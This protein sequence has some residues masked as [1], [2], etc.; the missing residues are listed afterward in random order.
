VASIA[1]RSCSR[2]SPFLAVSCC[3][4]FLPERASDDGVD[5]IEERLA[6]CAANQ[7]SPYAMAS[8]AFAHA[9]AGHGDLPARAPTGT[10]AT[11]GFNPAGDKLLRRRRAA[12]I[13]GGL[14]YAS[15]G[16]DVRSVSYPLAFSRGQRRDPWKLGLLDSWCGR[17]FE[18]PR[19]CGRQ[20]FK[21]VRL[22]VP[23]KPRIE[24]GAARL[25]I[26]EGDPC[27]APSVAGT[28]RYLWRTESAKS[29]SVVSELCHLPPPEN[30]SKTPSFTGTRRDTS[31]LPEAVDRKY[32]GMVRC[33]LARAKG[34]NFQRA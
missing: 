12:R 3:D 34:I 32:F 19:P 11:D 6:V 9:E 1:A 2:R 20:P 8:S 26:S 17:G 15:S 29:Q 23:P 24:S 27:D 4:S 21:L 5:G 13:L 14:C 30:L 28:C 7:R 18:L 31:L 33:A 10:L 22:P 16:R 25:A